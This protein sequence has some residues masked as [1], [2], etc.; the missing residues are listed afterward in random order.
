MVRSGVTDRGQTWKHPGLIELGVRAARALNIRGAANIQ[1]KWLHG[2][3]KVFEVN[4]RFSGGIALTI[5]AGADFPAWLIEMRLGRRV[6]P[7]MGDFTDGL[8]MSC[9]ESAIFLPH[10]VTTF[11]REAEETQ[12][13][14]SQD[15][16]PASRGR[17]IAHG[18]WI[19]A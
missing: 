7:A 18:P 10:Q 4:P 16:A 2:R 1:V 14:F 9:Y 11:D 13:G 17:M 6:R 19:E 3:G 8:L 12:E 5:A 15:P